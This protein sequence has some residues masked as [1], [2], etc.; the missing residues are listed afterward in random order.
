M[1]KFYKND[2]LDAFYER[3]K[4]SFDLT[5]DPK[6]DV[7]VTKIHT[8][9]LGKEY[10]RSYKRCVLKPVKKCE[11]FEKKEWKHKYRLELL[12][13]EYLTEEEIE[14][15]SFFGKLKYYRC[16]RKFEREIKR[17]KKLV[18]KGIKLFKSML[19]NTFFRSK[20]FSLKAFSMG[21]KLSKFFPFSKSDNKTCNISILPPLTI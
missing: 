12:D 13:F 15:L 5:V 19:S 2:L 17:F 18:I 16:E 14:N 21:A 9:N 7:E 4:E 6:E 8:A 20:S 3:Y 1:D 11:K 10:K